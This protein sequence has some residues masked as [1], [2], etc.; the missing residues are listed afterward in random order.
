MKKLSLILV[1]LTIYIL[2]CVSQNTTI[3][4]VLNG[5]FGFESFPLFVDNFGNDVDISTGSGFSIGADYS[6]DFS[7]Y[8]NVALSNLYQ[9]SKLSQQAK[10]ADGKFMR[11]ATTITPSFLIPL[12][13]D[14]YFRILVGA[15]PGIYSFGTMKIDAS[16]VGGEKMTLKYK[17]AL[18]LQ[19]TILFQMRVERD[20]Y[21]GI[22][23]KYY[24]VSYTFTEKGS[25][26]YS[27]IDKINKP[28]GS[29]LALILGFY[30]S[31]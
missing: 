18:G 15:G 16:Q 20:G 24:K 29:G 22:G 9:V 30:Q 11:M 13:R 5:G 3:G 17:T 26:H 19:S 10:N 7:R 28:N 31:F 23:G 8:F 6:Y 25:T 4:L 14:G 12:G 1:S 2:P 27:T 21:V